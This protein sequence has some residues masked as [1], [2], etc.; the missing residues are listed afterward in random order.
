MQLMQVQSLMSRSVY[1]CGLRDT[2]DR[3][4]QI[5]WDHDVGAVPVI[6]AKRHVVGIVTDRDACM[7]AYTRGRP[8][9]EISIDEVMSRGVVAVHPED[10]LVHAEQLM[11]DAQVRR[12]PVVD[13]EGRLCGLLSQNDLV[14]AAG[15]EP[16]GREL[17]ADEVVLTLSTIGRSRAS[18]DAISRTT[19]VEH[20][21]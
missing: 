12:L 14:R 1:A 3:A 15:G 13:Y 21:P 20:E 9:T 19:S 11:R 18:S 6:D 7:A 10:S 5:M 2:L 17:D 4:A 16:S 8:L